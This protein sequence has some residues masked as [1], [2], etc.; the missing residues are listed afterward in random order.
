M[1]DKPGSP[2]QVQDIEIADLDPT[3]VLV[4]IGVTGICHT[5]VAWAD[6]ELNDEFPVV[7]GHESAGTVEAVG[8]SV[9]RVSPGDRV[10][11]SLTQHCGQCRYCESGRPILCAGKTQARQRLFRGDEPLVQGFGTGGMG[12]ATAVPESGVVRIPNDVPL[13]VAAVAGCAVATGIGAVMNIAEVHPGSTVAVLG[14]G[15]I[16]ASALMG[17]RVSGA[18]RI[19]AVDPNRQRRQAAAKFGATD[20]LEPDEQKIRALEPD[21]FDYVFECTGKTEAMETA[22]RLTSIGGTVVLIGAPPPG[23]TLTIDALEFVKS[24]SR[25]LACLT[26][27][28][29]PNIDF[30]IFFR[31]YQGGLLDLDALISES[32]PLDEV[33]RGFD[34]ARRGEGIRTLVTMPSA[35]SS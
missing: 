30:P 32:V 26:G 14:T 35:T 15:G 6:G 20:Q 18:G 5:D 25:I 31:L 16:G 34:L 24:Q 12:E 33:E 11:L 28:L 27:N 29:R 21:G 9:T 4:R 3:E 1:V 19:V 17:A 7:L 8:S 13:E 10:M 23:S 22:V 2:P